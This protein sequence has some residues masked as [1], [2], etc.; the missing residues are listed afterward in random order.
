MVFKKLKCYKYSTLL[1]IYKLQ[2]TNSIKKYRIA[3][4][5]Y[6]K[7][8]QETPPTR[9]VLSSDSKPLLSRALA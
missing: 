9:P 8:E 2:E 5:A 4:H 6:K 7:D 1:E 3:L